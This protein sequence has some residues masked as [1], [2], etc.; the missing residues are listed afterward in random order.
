MTTPPP[1]LAAA[2]CRPPPRSLASSAQ[3][4]LR[5]DPPGETDGQLFEQDLPCRRGETRW[6]R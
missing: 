1:P 5:R 4:E 6:R 3:L 2:S